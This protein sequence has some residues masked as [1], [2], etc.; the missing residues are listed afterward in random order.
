M[1]IKVILFVVLIIATIVSAIWAGVS[2]FGD[3]GNGGKIGGSILTIL[4][5]VLTIGIELDEEYFKEA[6]GRIYGI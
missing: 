4:F 1:A 5:L 2:L 6:E 3:G